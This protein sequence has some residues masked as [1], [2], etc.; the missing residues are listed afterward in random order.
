MSREALPFSEAPIIEAAMQLIISLDVEFLGEESNDKVD[1]LDKVIGEYLDMF[2]I[3]QGFELEVL[4]SGRPEWIVPDPAP[5]CKMALRRDTKASFV[6]TGAYY[7]PLES[8][9]ATTYRDSDGCTW[10]LIRIA[11]TAPQTNAT[12]I[13]PALAAPI[14]AEAVERENCAALIDTML[15]EPAYNK[16]SRTKLALMIAARAI[17]RGRHLS[18]YEKME[19]LKAFCAGESA[20]PEPEPGPV[21]YAS[22]KDYRKNHLMSAAQYRNALPKNRVDFDVPLYA[23]APD[24]AARREEREE[25]WTYKIQYG[26]DG[27]ANYAWIYH[28]KE[29]VATMRTHFARIICD[30]MNEAALEREGRE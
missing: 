17:R 22:S 7:K 30:E 26:P 29:M 11:G 19:N 8:I 14:D 23:L 9:N 12:P 3:V 15:T 1:L 2:E 21:A 25:P 27:E 18:A 13:P 28:G 5:R 20:P 10:R 4:A 24:T 6:A 16:H